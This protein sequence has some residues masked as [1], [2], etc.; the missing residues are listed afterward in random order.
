ML[1]FLP[2]VKLG[3]SQFNRRVMLLG[4]CQAAALAVVVGRLRYLQVMESERLAGLAERNRINLRLI[5]PER[6]LIYDRDGRL[7]AANQKLFKIMMVREETSDPA[8]TLE[9]LGQVLQMSEELQRTTLEKIKTSRQDVP[10]VVI[11]EASWDQVARISANAPALPGVQATVGERRYYPMGANAVHLIGY[12]GKVSPE[13]LANPNDTD[14]LLEI[15]DFR[16]GRSGIEKS[17]DRALRGRSGNQQIEVNA[18]GR[19]MR[20]LGSVGARHGASHQLT[21]DSTQQN[22][23]MARLG[24]HRASAVVMNIK[25][26]DIISMASTPAFDPNQIVAGITQSEFDE[27]RNH[28]GN[29]MF[30][31]PTQGTYPPGSTFKMIT[32]LAALEEGL[33]TPDEVI[34]CQG[35]TEIS[36]RAF[37]CWKFNGHGNISLESSLS[38]SCDIFYYTLAERVSLE[39]L[40]EVANRFGIGVRPKLPISGIENGHFP[41]RASKLKIHDRPWSIGDMINTSIGQGDM[42]ASALQLTIMTARLASGLRV[43]PRLILAKEGKQASRRTFLPIGISQASLDLVR[44]GMNAAVNNV[45]GTAFDS[46]TADESFLIAGKTGTS[47]VRIISARERERGL[48]PNEELPLSRRDHALFCCYAPIDDPLFAATVIVEHGGS[49]ARVAAPIARDLLMRAHYGGIPSLRMYPPEVREEVKEIFLNLDL[50]PQPQ[51]L[52][53]QNL[54]SGSLSA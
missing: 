35:V 22:F 30:S 2:E 31:R 15:P 27:I 3:R 7:M 53:L 10:V 28:E 16:V 9:Q 48:T 18:Y 52:P 5:I 17:L 23:A 38:E 42:L 29:P 37:H 6:G 8:L 54:T 14:P 40:W 4:I 36:G 47:Q 32:A 13:D 34:N 43:E 24:E 46:R 33:I 19:I 12:V 11:E 41:S 50:S 39:K 25:N 26:G 21:I 44:N 1:T 20:E 49:G 45:L 51:G